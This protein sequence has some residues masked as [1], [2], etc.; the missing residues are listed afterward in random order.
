MK[1]VDLDTLPPGTHRVAPNLFLSVRNETSKSWLFRARWNGST[2]RIGLGSYFRV[3]LA[4]V[5]AKAAKLQTEVAEGRDP[6]LLFAADKPTAE[7]PAKKIPTFAEVAAMAI[8]EKASVARWKNAKH[9]WQWTA[10]VEKYAIPVLGKLPIDQITQKDVL[11]ALRPIWETKTETA[12]RVRGRLETIFNYAIREGL[13]TAANPAVWKGNLEFKLPA[14]SKVQPVEHLEA[15]TLPE[16]KRFT[17]HALASPKIGN[18]ATLFGIL[19]ATRANEFC[20]AEWSQIDL[21]EK[22]WA[23]PAA[24]RKDGK[25]YSHRVPLSDLAVRVLELARACAEHAERDSDAVFFGLRNPHVNLQTPRV[26]LMKFLGRH[27]TM[28]GCRSTFR[29]WAAE[30]GQNFDATEL[31]LMHEIGNKVTRAYYRTDLLEP[32][33]EIMQA[34]ADALKS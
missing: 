21:N 20:R 3:P 24:Y 18:L 19:T 22:V 5:K 25:H 28:H 9:T 7:Q 27:L 12:S 15:P 26:L 33:R 34:W 14:R 11:K 29:D 32:R 23:I 16:L 10:S 2:V 13:R 30:T 1:K 17:A 6:R 4:A 31:C 8:E